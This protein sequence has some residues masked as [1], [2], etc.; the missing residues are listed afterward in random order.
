MADAGGAATVYGILFQILRSLKY[1]REMRLQ[2][3]K[4]SGELVTANLILEPHDGGDLQALGHGFRIVEQCKTRRSGRPWSFRELTEEVFPDLLRAVDSSRL[5]YPTV[6]RFATD[7]R[8]SDWSHARSLFKSMADMGCPADPY[9][10]LQGNEGLKKFFSSRSRAVSP[11][12]FFRE[13]VANVAK[14]SGSP[15]LTQD[16]D[17][18]RRVWHVAANFEASAEQ[19]AEELLIRLEDVISKLTDNPDNCEQLRN[20]LIARVLELSTT[21]GTT[22]SPT[23]F[24]R[25]TG[26]DRVSL[27]SWRLVFKR[28]NEGTRNEL[29]SL[30]GYKDAVDVRRPDAEYEGTNVLLV[31]GDADR[32]AVGGSGCGKSFYLGANANLAIDRGELVVTTRALGSAQRTL[33]RIA[34]EVWTRGFRRHSC[35]SLDA[36]ANLLRRECIG[37]SDVWLT[38]IVDDLSSAEEFRELME[39]PWREHGIRLI[40]AIPDDFA[41]VVTPSSHAFRVHNLQEFSGE[42]LREY[43]RRR[44]V[45]WGSLPSDMRQLLRWPLLAQLYCDVAGEGSF[46]PES[47]YHLFKRT[48]N[49]LSHDPRQL[50]HRDDQAKLRELVAST[51]IG[52]VQYPWRIKDCIAHGIDSHAIDRLVNVGWGLR[53]N[54]SLRIRHHRLLSWAIAEAITYECLRACGDAIEMA[55]VVLCN[56]SGRPTVFDKPERAYVAMDLLWL[57]ADPNLGNPPLAGTVIDLLA[58]ENNWGQNDHLFT[59]MIPTLGVR[60]V[61][62]VTAIIRERTRERS[63]GTIH[64][65]ATSLKKIGLEFSEEVACEAVKLLEENSIDAIYC[66][67]QILR[68]F[69][70]GK[71][72]NGLWKSRKFVQENDDEGR[73]ISEEYPRLEK[74]IIQAIIAC[75]TLQP[76]WVSEKLSGASENLDELDDLA[77]ILSRIENEGAT[78]VWTDC[79]KSLADQLSY[80]SRG[81][82]KCIVRF[83]DK[84]LASLLEEWT[85]SKEVAVQSRGM[86]ALSLVDPDRARKIYR[87]GFLTE[88]QFS[89]QRWIQA[90]FL[91][92]SDDTTKTLEQ[93]IRTS[94][95]ALE[96]AICAGQWLNACSASIV[97]VISEI[98]NQA[99]RAYEANPD[100]E[101]S[102]R[103]LRGLRLL[104]NITRP[105]MLASL[106]TYRDSEFEQR[107][108]RIALR[109]VDEPFVPHLNLEV[110]I[111]V[112]RH[113]GGNGL[114]SITNRML[115]SRYRARRLKGLDLA[116]YS[117]DDET[118]TAIRNI[119]CELD[120]GT[121]EEKIPKL[122]ILQHRAIIRLAELKDSRGLVGALLVRGH[123]VTEL[124]DIRSEAEP[125]TD[126]EIKPIVDAIDSGDGPL[127]NLALR[128]VGVTGRKDLSPLLLSHEA[129]SA[130]SETSFAAICGLCGLRANDS[131]SIAAFVRHLPI[132]RHHRVAV[133][134]LLRSNEP[135][136][137]LSLLEYLEGS[138]D[139]SP[140]S[141]DSQVA[142]RLA[143]Y[144]PLRERAIKLISTQP[145]LTDS[146]RGMFHPREQLELVG[147][148]VDV[149]VSDA[150]HDA[151]NPTEGNFNI[152]GRKAAAIRGLAKQSPLEAEDAAVRAL[153]TGKYDREYIPDVLVEIK[154]DDA[155][156]VLLDHMAKESNHL[157]RRAIG[158][159]LRRF[160]CNSRLKSELTDRLSSRSDEI[161][162]GTADVLGWV[163]PDEMEAELESAYRR[164]YSA[165][166]RDALSFAIVR[167]QMQ[168]VMAELLECI[169]KSNG[170]AQWD[171]VDALFELDDVRLLGLADD[172]L[173]I[174]EA[175]YDDLPA[176]LQRHF[177]ERYVDWNRKTRQQLKTRNDT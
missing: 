103:F 114:T 73:S 8:I 96:H 1:I 79:K 104:A 149:D 152:E 177:D 148:L 48:W 88:S 167:R 108:T 2:G 106:R 133:N 69:P 176:A 39:F 142:V 147:D 164:E 163:G 111:P 44:D 99:A 143:N 56:D 63:I 144:V 26:L 64:Q 117:P 77:Y 80:G 119:A 95:R 109:M 34:N 15:E 68:Q 23:E 171:M 126:E 161:R 124:A 135:Q 60:A 36:V 52:E 16:I 59:V 17:F 101:A 92:N 154:G 5:A 14:G 78:V 32:N 175:I 131:L 49:R 91:D 139:T 157:V 120:D 51:I 89:N 150:L 67:V 55:K 153:A 113:I 141:V 128:A 90:L 3:V 136:A 138:F 47:E 162:R 13:V 122:E 166:C 19:T 30:F 125:M 94:E 71:A 27:D 57:I 116:A 97:R 41:K 11:R 145:S 21:T 82:A 31:T 105:K 18:A 9:A 28:L 75:A 45:N 130:E 10:E 72:L 168:K 158:I 25:Q 6:F 38:V 129:G 87:E 115:A 76:S 85:H 43:L 70:L 159:S 35:M 24:C 50:A 151:A 66:A 137:W 84:S 33:D 112:L 74:D 102:S 110:V 42:E 40:T 160:S 118:I 93:H 12:E 123:G 169:P 165:R 65:V 134:G 121:P 46:K 37:L 20:D 86:E 170:I 146:F 22:L 7:G 172:P 98:V 83:G 156:P 4:E 61:P 29:E 107:L 155:I 174:G 140:M 53:E 173:W 100:T 54:G 132:R 58:S 127:V 81:L 62:I